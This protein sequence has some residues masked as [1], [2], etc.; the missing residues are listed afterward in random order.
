MLN[1]REYLKNLLELDIQ[2]FTGVPDSLLKDFCAC[3]TDR[4]DEEQHVIAANEGAAIGLAIGRYIANQS[5]P[6]VYMQNSGLGNAVNPLLSLAHKA[7]YGIPML[8]MLGWRGEPDKPDEPQH[9]QQGKVMLQ[10]LDAMEIPY[11]ILSSET[12]KAVEQTKKAIAQAID[13]TTPVAL[14]VK[15]GLFESYDAPKAII[16]PE[17]LSRERAIKCAA[18]NVNYGDVIVATT[19]MA[20]RELFE[21]RVSSGSSVEQDFL[22]VGGMGHASQIAMGIAT[23]TKS[24]NVYCFD[25]DGAALMHMGSLAIS[26]QSKAENFVH[27]V[28]NNGVHDSVGGQPTVCN[29][30]NLVEIAHN[31]GYAFVERVCTETEIVSAMKAAVGTSGPAFIEICVN[32]GNRK[33]IGRPTSSPS[34]NKFALMSYLRSEQS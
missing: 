33:D 18:G 30:I 11:E 15:K 17:L 25:G 23:G 29:Q 24:R 16:K 22:T 12:E 34:E 7:V 14:I 21:Y 20:S 3:V 5:V 26:G 31:C 2:F 4:L 13:N 28:F 10:M 6:M 32:P 8:V 19:G 27:I 9:V 1:P